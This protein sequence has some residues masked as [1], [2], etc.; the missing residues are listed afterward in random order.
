[1]AHLHSIYDCDTHFVIDLKTR[2]IKNDIGKTVI[3]QN[4]HNSERFS[5]ELPK[6]IEG[7]DMSRCNVVQVHYVNIDAKTKEQHEGSYEVE[8]LQVSPD[9]NDVVILSWLLSQNATRAVGNLY[10]GIVF[11][12]IEKDGSLTYSWHTTVNKD[13]KVVESLENSDVILEEYPDILAQFEARFAALEEEYAEKLNEAVGLTESVKQLK[14]TASLKQETANALQANAIGEFVR[15][16]DVS[17]VEHTVKVK[18]SGNADFSTVTLHRCGKNL[19]NVNNQKPYYSNLDTYNVEDNKYTLKGASGKALAT[20]SGVFQLKLP[21]T[22]VNYN[23]L[24]VSIYVTLLTVGGFGNSIRITDNTNTQRYDIELSSNVRTKISVTFDSTIC[25]PKAVTFYVNNNELLFEADTMQAEI[26][27][28]ATDFSEYIGTSCAFSADGTAEI[29]SISPTMTLFTDTEG[30]NIE[31]EYNQ[32]INT[33]LDNVKEDV[34]ELEKV[35]SELL[36]GGGNSEKPNINI[37]DVFEKTSG[38]VN[39]YQPTTEGWIDNT[40]IYADGSTKENVNFCLTGKIPVKPNTTYSVNGWDKGWFYCY[41]SNDNYIGSSITDLASG[42]VDYA[43]GTTKENTAYIR[44][45]LQKEADLAITIE[46]F[47]SSF[48]I[49][50]GVGIVTSDYGFKTLIREIGDLSL[51]NVEDKYKK[52]LVTAI[53]QIMRFSTLT[54][55]TKTEIAKEAVGMIDIPL[56]TAIGSGVLE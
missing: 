53:N 41:D 30:T 34:R 28:T 31:I 10:F 14:E 36:N 50:E 38:S 19:F 8:D 20:S 7:H 52:N 21:Q 3:V 32:D 12:C 48:I 17:P 5:F 13:F 22:F 23:K 47:N 27:D 11:K 9:D 54:E 42:D 18:A 33:V 29:A 16:D 49:V 2:E 43:Y 51:L 6:E 35:T 40:I 45:E 44:L 37:D 24:T 26:G 4:D 15:I 1:M 46:K 56:S 39:L 55:E 25:S